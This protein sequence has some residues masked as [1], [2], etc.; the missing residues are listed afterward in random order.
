MKKIYL[1][2]K[3][4]FAIFGNAPAELKSTGAQTESQDHNIKLNVVYTAIR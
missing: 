1:R 3:K 2:P 4:P